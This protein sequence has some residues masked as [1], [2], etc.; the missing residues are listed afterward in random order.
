MLGFDRFGSGDRGVIILNDWLSDTST[1]DAVRPYL[2]RDRLTWVFADLRGYGRSR[3]QSGDFTLI[4]AARDV[5]ALADSLGWRRF[6]LV[7]L[8][9]AQHHQDA[10]ERAVLVTPSPPTGFGLDDVTLEVFRDAALGDDTRRLSL[11]QQMQATRLSEQWIR[12]KLAR[13]RASA[14]PDAVAGYTA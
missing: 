5:I 10:I 14:D 9:L 6:C 12:F 11:L 7:A 13:W 2:G 1:W 8:Y 3:G 4:E